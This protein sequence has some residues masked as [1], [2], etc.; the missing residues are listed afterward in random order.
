MIAQPLLPSRT[1]LEH[2]LR[3][4]I[5]QRL[6]PGIYLEET[7]WREWLYRH[8][9]NY[10]TAEFAE[11][12][13]RFWEW[14]SS[15]QAKVKPRPRAECWPRGG[16]KSSTIELGCAYLGSAPHPSRHFVLYVSETQV[17]A[18]VHVQAVATMLER[19]GVNRAVNQYG[20]SKGWTQTQVR[21]MN[22]FNIQAFGLDAG[23]RG[24]KLDEFRPD[25]IVM[26][27]IDGRHDSPDTTAKKIQVITQSIL[28]AG[29]TD[30]AV[31]VVQ[32][33]IAKNS[34]MSQLC[35]GRADFLI[36]RVVAEE[37]AVT[38][39][40]VEQ[41]IQPDGTPKYIIT[42]G[43]ATWEGQSLDICEGQINE[44]GLG[45][46]RREAQHEV[47]EVDGGLWDRE[48]DIE[49]WRV[50]PGQELP[51]MYRIIVA[52]DP[53]GSSEGDEIGIVVAGISNTWD[54]R[55]TDVPHAYVLDDLSLHGSS[56]T[57]AEEA[58]RAYHQHRADSLIAERNF[59]GEMV[60]ATIATIPGAP[61]V[62]LVWASRGKTI[63]A[64]PVHKLYEDGRVHHVKRFDRMERELCTWV[65][66]M[67]SPNRLDAVVWAI[68]SLIGE[69]PALR[70]VS[71]DLASYITSQF[72]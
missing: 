7:P 18:N 9:R 24:I 44:W 5:A 1:N 63:R 38:D 68:S 20:A 25:V 15:L 11:R 46:F 16:G 2:L 66:G 3:E 59:G 67:P 12:H 13:V 17:Q 10:V 57:W 4:T 60:S 32:N 51:P 52:V 23:M 72:R 31:I 37:P 30:C 22:G 61:P 49:Q 39:L 71:G 41:V 54:E 6:D 29:S 69:S 33:R 40:Q 55:L 27:D 45:S 50:K 70:P 42:G 48:R 53:A 56:K 26:D 35:D 62:E 28:P 43:T 65:Q 21:A 34:I 64:E 47:D 14:I 58:V 8:F 19:V 36:D